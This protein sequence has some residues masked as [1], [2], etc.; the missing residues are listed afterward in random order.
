MVFLTLPRPSHLLDG[1]DV[2]LYSHED[3][4]QP[5]RGTFP[6]KGP[7]IPGA[8]PQIIFLISFAGVVISK[9]VLIRG[10]V[11]LFIGGDF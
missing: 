6:I 9:A 4:N 5:G 3:I 1:S 10:F 8:C 11:I 2:S 7:D